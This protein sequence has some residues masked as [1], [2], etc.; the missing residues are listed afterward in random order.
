MT[1]TRQPTATPRRILTAG[2]DCTA[3]AVRDGARV[4]IHIIIPGET[5]VT[6][7]GCDLRAGGTTKPA[8]EIQQ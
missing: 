7:L 6:V 1:I 3:F 5:P 2:R 8:K 4:N